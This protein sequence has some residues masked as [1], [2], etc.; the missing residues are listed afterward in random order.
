MKVISPPS[1]TAVTLHINKGLKKT[2]LEDYGL[3]SA[4]GRPPLGGRTHIGPSELCRTWRRVPLPLLSPA[5]WLDYFVSF[6]LYFARNN[7]REGHRI[8]YMIGHHGS[9]PPPPP[10]NFCLCTEF[11]TH[12]WTRLW[13]R[14]IQVPTKLVKSLFK[15]WRISRR[16]PMMIDGHSDSPRVNRA[17]PKRSVPA[18]AIFFSCISFS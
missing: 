12:F 14:V 16:F 3:R 7:W 9:N 10:P 15:S 6:S 8:H 13:T 2:Q 17:L 5:G 1:L 18:A 11:L 4:D